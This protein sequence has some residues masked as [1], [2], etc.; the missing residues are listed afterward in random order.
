MGKHMQSYMSSVQEVKE[1]YACRR[2]RHEQLC[3]GKVALET[4]DHGSIHIYSPNK[5]DKWCKVKV[6]R[7][8]DELKIAE[9]IFFDMMFSEN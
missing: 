5:V 3:K 7:T 9:N 6:A 8:A 2:R 4:L 1:N